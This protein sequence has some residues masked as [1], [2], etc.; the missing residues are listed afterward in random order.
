MRMSSVLCLTCS[1]MMAHTFSFLIAS[2]VSSE[3][4]R[5]HNGKRKDTNIN[6]LNKI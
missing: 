5:N 1:K 6:S 2:L 3:A 4:L